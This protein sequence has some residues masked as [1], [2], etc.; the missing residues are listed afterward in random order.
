MNRSSVA[1]LTVAALVVAGL[2]VIAVRE[3]QA[4]ALRARSA[5]NLQQ[6]SEGMQAFVTAFGFFPGNGGPP[7]EAVDTP[8]VRTG[9]PDSESFRWGYA[10]PK[11]AGRLQTGCWA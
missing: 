7:M 3:A 1:V 2:G 4:K 5:R 6:I 10:D 11:R 9:F 8:D